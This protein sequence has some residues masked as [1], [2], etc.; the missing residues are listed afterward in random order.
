MRKWGNFSEGKWPNELQSTQLRNFASSVFPVWAAKGPHSTSLGKF[1]QCDTGAYL[2]DSAFPYFKDLLYYATA[3]RY[4]VSCCWSHFKLPCYRSWNL[5]S[6]IQCAQM[7]CVWAEEVFLSYLL[8][9]HKAFMLFELK[10]L[11]SCLAWRAIELSYV[12]AVSSVHI[13]KNPQE[14]TCRWQVN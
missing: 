2:C 9:C 1:S 13:V 6:F 4:A 11:K 14:I 12:N 10:W 5:L 3:K 8:H 7:H